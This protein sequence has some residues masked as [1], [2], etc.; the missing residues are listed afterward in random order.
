VL[1][2]LNTRAKEALRQCLP[3][4]LRDQTFAQVIRSE[5]TVQV[6]FFFTSFKYY[7]NLLRIITAMDDVIAEKYN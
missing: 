4:A 3:D 7:F 1:I 6:C 5:E 2:Y